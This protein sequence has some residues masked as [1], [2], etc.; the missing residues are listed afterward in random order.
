MKILITITYYNPYISGLTNSVEN[1]AKALGHDKYHI[2][3]LAS[4]HDKN[5]PFRENINGVEVKRVSYFFKVSKG[6]FMPFYIWHAFNSIRK[7]DRVIV[8]LPQ[9]EGFI[10]VLISKL[11]N[12]KLYC[13]YPC[14]ISLPKSFLNLMIE[15]FL[16]I[17]NFISLWCSYKIIT[18]TQDYADKSKLIS[19]FSKKTK[20]I[21]PLIH[22]PK[23][24]FSIQKKIKEKLPKGD[25]YHIGFIGRIASEKGIEYLLDAIPF[26]EK[27]SNCDF[28]ILIAGPPNPAGE[29]RYFRRILSF[30]DKYKKHLFFFGTLSFE[31]MGSFYSLLDVLVLPS[32]NSTE[33]FGMVQVEAM[34][35]G[36]PVVASNLPGVRVPIIATGMGELTEPKNSQDL[37]EKIVKIL[38]DKKK[39]IKKRKFIESKFSFKHTISEYE[40]LFT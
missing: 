13:Y 12:K 30:F 1:L 38:K 20:F 26:L 19:F 3:V 29:E 39:Y 34:L 32:V 5:L 24:S 23:R 21:L 9:L 2:F 35:C 8:V 17:A 14:D 4:Q 18:L 28:L 7:V 27:K 10:V 25:G 16:H 37:A 22:A 6:F 15:N 33:A 40:R 31:E 36:I 11:L